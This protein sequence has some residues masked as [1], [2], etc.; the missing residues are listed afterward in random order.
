AGWTKRDTNAIVVPESEDSLSARLY[1]Q[2]LG[3]LYTRGD[4]DFVM[5][6]I[7]YGDTQNDTLQLHRPEVCYPA[8]GFELTQSSRTSIALDRNV[9]I[10]GRTLT[11]SMPDRIEHI[12]YW[13]RI[14]E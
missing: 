1:S 7:A 4:N 9:S 2:T 5:M 8:F 10:P 14:G 3:R 6:L 13:T 12:T 11:A